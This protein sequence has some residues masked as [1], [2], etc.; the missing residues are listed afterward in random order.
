LETGAV[1]AGERLSDGFGGWLE[2]A[3]YRVL[4]REVVHSSGEAANRSLS[5]EAMQNSVHRLPAADV[6]EIRRNEHGTTTT[7]TNCGNYPRINAL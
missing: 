5:R 2:W 1:A 7:A 3:E 4:F 6:Q